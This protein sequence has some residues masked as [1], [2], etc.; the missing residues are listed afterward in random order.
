MN[1]PD[2][3]QEV[4]L[5][6]DGKAL[7]TAAEDGLHVVPVS[8][9]KILD[10]QIVLVDYF[11]GKTVKNILANPKIALACWRGLEGYQVKGEVNYVTEGETFASIK[12]WAEG[13]FP[14]RIVKGI[15]L[16]TPN[17]VYDVSATVERPGVKLEV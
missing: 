1:L 12:E 15:L 8:T 13:M 3:I 17:E 9:V 5:N 11:M 7:A 6:A 4:I 10:E 14:D 16:I 2:K